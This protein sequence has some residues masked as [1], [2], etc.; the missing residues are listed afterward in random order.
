M[1]AHNGDAVPIYTIGYGARSLDA[2]FDV[3]ADQGITHLIDVRSAPYSK[4]KPEFSKNALEVAARSRGIRYTYMGDALG[5]QPKD[6]S[7]YEDGKVL[8]DRVRE[9][10]YFAEGIARLRKAHDLGLRVAIMCSEGKPEQCHR[11]ALI[12]QVLADAGIPLAHIDE[13]DALIDQDEAVARR[14]GGQLSLLDDPEFKSR[15]RYRGKRGAE[16]DNRADGE[17]DD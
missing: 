7:C 4:F 14:T 5:G 9:R 12:G 16:A 13:N 10:P 11:T 6:D 8:Y 3:L 2:F 17:D 1:S 15:K